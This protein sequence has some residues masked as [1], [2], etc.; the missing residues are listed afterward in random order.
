MKLCTSIILVSMLSG[1]FAANFGT[2][3]CTPP[4]INAGKLPNYKYKFGYCKGTGPDT[5][6]FACSQTN[7]CKST[8]GCI[9]HEPPGS[10]GYANCS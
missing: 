1:A 7:P 4:P 6:S 10:V 9:I 8:Q 3:T 5:R 2:T